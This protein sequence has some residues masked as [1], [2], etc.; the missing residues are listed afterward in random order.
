MQEQNKMEEKSNEATLQ[1]PQGERTIDAPSVTI[2][3]H[4][5]KAYQNATCA[6]PIMP[7][8]NNSIAAILYFFNCL[9]LQ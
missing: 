3:V 1:R 7:S 5:E 4:S 2:K 8:A 9:Y 6:M